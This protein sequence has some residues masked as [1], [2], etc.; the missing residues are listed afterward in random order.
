MY[1][2]ILGDNLNFAQNTN[3]INTRP[4]SDSKFRSQIEARIRLIY[5]YIYIYINRSLKDN[6]N[7]AHRSNHES[8]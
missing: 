2:R 5:I 6:L 1:I 8:D 3:S 7:C 4:A